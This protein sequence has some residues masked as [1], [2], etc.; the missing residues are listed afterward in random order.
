MPLHIAIPRRLSNETFVR[1]LVDAG[2][3]ISTSSTFEDSILY[4][5]TMDGTS[6][7]AQFLLQREAIPAN[8][9]LNGDTLLH[10]PEGK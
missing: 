1:L 7:M 6:S 2:A 5:A 8:W 4:L 3:D 10:C 9:N